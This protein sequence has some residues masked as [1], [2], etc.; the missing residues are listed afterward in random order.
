LCDRPSPARTPLDET[1]ALQ[2]VA[3]SRSR[4]PL[5]FR[6]FIFQPR[7]DFLRAE[8]RKSPP[9]GDDALGDPIRSRMWAAR[10]GMAQ[11]LKPACLSTFPAPLPK[12]ERLTADAV[13]PAQ[14]ANRENPRLVLTK[15]R[16]T[17]FH[18]TG[19]LERHRPISSNRATTL[20][21]HRDLFEKVSAAVAGPAVVTFFTSFRYPVEIEDADC[22]MLQSVL[23]QTD[24]SK[25]L[26]LMI[27]SPGGDTLAAERIVNICRAYKPH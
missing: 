10:G 9:H 19:L 21:C 22:D 13:P 23:Q 15:Q 2:D 27:S 25:G 24:Q 5:H 18:R 7:L 14:L 16:D 3:N 1:F 4:R 6:R 12:V 17:L 11:F 26:V 20:T 8:M